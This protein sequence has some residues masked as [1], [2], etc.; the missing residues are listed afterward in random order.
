MDSTL[1]LSVSLDT[2][3]SRKSG[4]GLKFGDVSEIDDLRQGQAED[5]VEK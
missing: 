4:G 2:S 5:F 1:F 3:A